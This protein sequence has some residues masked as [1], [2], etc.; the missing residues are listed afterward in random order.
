MSGHIVKVLRAEYVNHNVRQFTVEKPEGYEY[1]SGQATD[2][3]LNLPKWKDELR[4]FTFTSLNDW[5]HLQFTIKIYTDRSSNYL[6]IGN[7]TL[8]IGYHSLLHSFHR[9]CLLTCLS[10]D[11]NFE[12]IATTLQDLVVVNLVCNSN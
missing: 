7:K 1:I 3:S 8:V 9:K 4:P 2:V 12:Y 6:Q 10:I 11:D 5:E